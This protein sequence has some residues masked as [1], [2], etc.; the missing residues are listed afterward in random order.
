MAESRGETRDEAEL[1]RLERDVGQLARFDA[2]GC[3]AE[4]HQ[5]QELE[6]A[7]SVEEASQVVQA[8]E[9]EH[10]WLRERRQARPRRHVEA[11]ALLRDIPSPHLSP[12][13]GDGQGRPV[14][15]R[16]GCQT[17]EHDY[18][19]TLHAWVACS[20]QPLPSS[21]L[22]RRKLRYCNRKVRP[23]DLHD[24]LNRSPMPRAGRGDRP[25]VSAAVL[26]VRS[27]RC[28]DGGH[29]CSLVSAAISKQSA[30]RPR[31]HSRRN[32]S[33]TSLYQSSDG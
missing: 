21:Q 15:P 16:D 10:V 1:L 30:A 9:W 33:W 28:V 12:S 5:T 6:Q 2:V 25:S 31:R 8:C 7:R 4:Q 22:C 29:A 13:D 14:V 20:S 32:Y 17:L 19:P 24:L 3:E 23:A 27:R 11:R 26:Q 18:P